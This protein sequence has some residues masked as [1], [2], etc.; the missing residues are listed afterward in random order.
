MPLV[1]LTSKENEEF[2][3]DLKVAKLSAT[4]ASL[5]EVC[6]FSNA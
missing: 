4:I 6:P 3:V 5:M 2:K 1:K